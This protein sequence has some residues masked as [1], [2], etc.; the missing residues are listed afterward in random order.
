M[1]VN[2]LHYDTAGSGP[3][4]LL[5]PG[6][7]LDATA[8][9]GLAPLL[10]DAF[11]VVTYDP[12]GLSRS[13]TED[14]R[15]ITVAGQA[16]DALAVLDAV[17]REPAH[18]FGHSGGALT[19]LALVERHPSRVRTAVL[20][21]PPL[22]DL[23]PDAVHIAANDR[24]VTE[25]YERDGVWAAAAVFMARAGLAEEGG[26]APPEE[27]LAAMESNFDVFFGRMY[28]S[29]G[30]Y[31]PDFA[32]LTAAS[33]TIEVGVGSTTVGELANR[34]AVA[35]AER[36]GR[37]TVEFPGDHNGFTTD[38]EASAVVLRKLLS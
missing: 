2:G 23:L 8:F 19:T 35:F 29:I 11:T 30:E 14:R 20:M 15:Q 21:E 7:P 6:G 3:T 33:T 32:A 36:L 5:V 10:A 31:S 1:I 38:P 9:D 26:E 18:V 17:S 28:R 37:P 4:L 24:L 27:W 16:A 34:A 13:A 22:V 25:A 12:R